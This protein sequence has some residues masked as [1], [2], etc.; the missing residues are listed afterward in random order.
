MFSKNEFNLK[1]FKQIDQKHMSFKILGLIFFLLFFTQCE[2]AH[3]TT[4]RKDDYE[5]RSEYNQYLTKN[6]L[7][8]TFSYQLN[9]Q[10]ID[11][12][13][14]IK[15]ALNFYK[16]EHGG[17]ASV[18]QLRMYNTAGHFIYGYEQCFGNID[19]FSILD[20]MPFKIEPNLPVNM[21]L[22]LR[23]DLN[24]INLTDSERKNILEQSLNYPYTI[25]ATYS[26]RWGYYSNHTIKHLK[27]YIKNFGNENFLII[28]VN[29][30][31]VK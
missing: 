8:T 28:Y 7:D 1:L 4:I 12:I 16:V 23:N 10:Y 2:I 3:L 5:P 27:K 18:S 24:W 22:S 6:G 26:I 19:Y 29:M 17:K 9:P 15:Y 14:N 11:S 25:I 21:N 31:R 20:S 30:T 13:S